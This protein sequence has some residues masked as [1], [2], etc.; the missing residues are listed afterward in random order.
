MES[1]CEQEEKLVSFQRG[2]IRAEEQIKDGFYPEY[3]VGLKLP[4]AFY[5]QCQQLSRDPPS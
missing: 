1:I 4:K 2:W 5:K 3:R